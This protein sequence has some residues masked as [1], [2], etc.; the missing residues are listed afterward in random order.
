MPSSLVGES[1]PIPT[2]SQN[3]Q[4]FPSLVSLIKEQSNLIKNL[5]KIIEGLNARLEKSEANEKTIEALN[6]RLEAY[7]NQNQNQNVT[8]NVPNFVTSE[9]HPKTVHEK[10]KMFEMI[11]DK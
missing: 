4:D 3:I 11:E 9:Q 5:H 2:S 7:E 1:V 6:K 10:E 8:K